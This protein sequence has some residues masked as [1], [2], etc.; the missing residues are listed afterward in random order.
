MAIRFP[1]PACQQPIEVDDAWGGSSVACPYCRKVIV[2]PRE[3]A[4]PSAEVPVASP[5]QSGFAPPPPPPGYRS[6][7]EEPTVFADP[8]AVKN[9]PGSANWALLLAAAGAI[10][11]GVGLLIWLSTIASLVIKKT[12]PN[13][14][15]DQLRKALIEVMPSAP[16]N[17]AATTVLFV[18]AFC[19]I[20]GLALAIR[21]LV[22]SEGD[23]IKA[24]VAC[25]LAGISVFC[26]VVMMLAMA[27]GRTGPP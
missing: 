13:P 1:C 5:A 7:P 24:I 16:T 12:G 2:A 27:G 25:L 8:Q 14:S 10:L 9:R 17:P 4:W 23:T 19:G 3:N 11:A 18:G 21:S 20:S 15:E 22:R 6:M 26:Q